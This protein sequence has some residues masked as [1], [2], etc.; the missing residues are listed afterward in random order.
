MHHF[1]KIIGILFLSLALACSNT[2]EHKKLIDHYYLLALDAPESMTLSYSDKGEEPYTQIVPPTIFE[3][4]WNDR[5]IIVKSHP[6]EFKKTVT[7]ALHYNFIKDLQKDTGVKNIEY[8]A[9]KLAEKEYYRLLKSGEF[10][11]IK[12]ENKNQFTIYYLLDTKDQ[13][14]QPIIFFTEKELDAALQEL[15]VGELPNKKYYEALD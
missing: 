2:F 14:K 11:K 3:A 10:D 13:N 5:F 1:K 9:D 12:K 15:K 6:Q 8:K 4:Q 7:E